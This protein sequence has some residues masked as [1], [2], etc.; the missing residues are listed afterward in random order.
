MKQLT[1]AFD[2]GEKVVEVV[3]D[4]TR[5]PAY[6]FHFLCLAELIFKSPAVSHVLYDHFAFDNR[7]AEHDHVAAQAGDDRVTI[8]GLPVGLKSF[9]RP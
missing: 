4:S 7:A 8:P 3:S 6:R 9:Y 5:Q 2:D 1:V